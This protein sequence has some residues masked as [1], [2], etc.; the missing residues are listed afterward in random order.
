MSGV[1]FAKAITLSPLYKERGDDF[2]FKSY[3]AI[4]LLKL[5]LI[6]RLHNLHNYT[7]HQ[8]I[9]Q[10]ITFYKREHFKVLKKIKI[11]KKVCNNR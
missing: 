8:K 6:H 1:R 9:V 5:K 3:F 10:Q 7:V 2:V 11:T 4:A